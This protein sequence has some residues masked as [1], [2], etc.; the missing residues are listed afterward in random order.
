MT[1]P[2][3][4]GGRPSPGRLDPV[5]RSFL[6]G[7][8]SPP[9]ADRIA[10]GLEP[11][12]VADRRAALGAASELLQQR[13]MVTTE[14]L[15][16][17][18]VRE[19]GQDVDSTAVTLGVDSSVV[20][21][22][23]SAED[24]APGAP[25]PGAAPSS[26]A[27][28]GPAAPPEAAP[29]PTP[30]DVAAGRVSTAASGRDGRRSSWPVGLGIV[31]GLAVVAVVAT[32]T[33]GGDAGDDGVAVPVPSDSETGT[34]AGADPTPTTTDGVAP[35]E[36]AASPSP[37]ATDGPTEPATDPATDG[38]TEDEVVDGPTALTELRF[39]TEIDVTT[40]EAAEARAT[41]R[42][43]EDVLAWVSLAPEPAAPTVVELTFE[44]PDGSRTVRPALVAAGNRAVAVRLPEELGRTPG[45]YAVVAEL[46][47]ADADPL[48]AEVQLEAG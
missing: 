31:A 32:A 45:R 35:T 36:P 46:R 6:R 43:D 21:A 25:P 13:F 42:P 47:G 15:A 17:S 11:V 20:L 39:V 19:A 10:A 40:G 22:A 29:P 28:T 16:A 30:I 2:P 48:R 14:A 8:L 1:V 3:Q 41:V 26:V 44:G 4:V 33:L 23:V 38:A 37:T 5:V 7:F 34:A 9:V 24:L 12:A 27:I 18:L